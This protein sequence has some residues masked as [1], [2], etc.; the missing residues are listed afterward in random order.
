MNGNSQTL[1]N[2][3][4]VQSQSQ[5]RTV[6]Q[7][8]PEKSPSRREASQE[9][10]VVSI[11]EVNKIELSDEMKFQ[12]RQR[13]GIIPKSHKFVQKKVPDSKLEDNEGVDEYWEECSEIVRR[14]NI[15]IIIS[16]LWFQLQ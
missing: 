3:I 6:D 1:S 16:N 9:N 7:F 8:S 2:P 12:M 15:F 10:P 13:L 11:L 14:F 4:I 5:D